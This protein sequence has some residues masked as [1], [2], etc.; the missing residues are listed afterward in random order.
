MSDSIDIGEIGR[1]MGERLQALEQERAAVA[2]ATARREEAAIAETAA[3][4]RYAEKV[5]EVRAEGFVTD[6]LLEKSGH[7]IGKRRGRPAKTAVAAAA[8]ASS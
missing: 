3:Q 1:I 7:P 2:E 4:K 6:V 5:E 8:P